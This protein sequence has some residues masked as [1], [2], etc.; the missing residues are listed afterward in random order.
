MPATFRSQGV[1]SNLKQERGYALLLVLLILVMISAIGLGMMY[2]SST[3]TAINGNYRDS[4]L[5]FSAMRG[6][7]EEARDRMRTNS[8]SPLNTAPNSV[9]AAMPGSL[10]SV[11]YITNAAGPTDTVDPLN[12]GNLYF[13]DEFCHE[14]FTGL[15]LSNPGAN[16]PCT[17]TM[18]ST[19]AQPYV[20]STSPYTNTAAALK[21][22]W[23]RITLKQN[24][25]M[26][27]ATVDA[28][29]PA[30]TQICYQTFSSQE[31]PLTL[32]P[33]GPYADCTAA[34]AAS[35]DAS[36]VY[37]LT[38]LAI[39]PQGSRR[40]GQ[41]EVAG[42]TTTPPPSA[43]GLD[44]PAAIFSPRP[45]SSLYF[46]NGTDSGAA[47]YT[48]SGGAGSCT[49]SGPANV[50]AISTGDSAGATAITTAITTNPDRSGN[51]T[52]SGG[53]P[54]VVNAGPG[55]TGQFSG[56]WSTPAQLDSLVNSLANAADVSYTCGIGAPC[57]PTGP[58]GTNANPQITYVNGDFNFGS[59]S[60]AGVLVVTGTLSFT[61]NASFN[62]LILV[63]GQGVVS[64]SG[65]GSGGFNGTMFLAK[66]HSSTSP[67]PELATLQSPLFSWNGGGSSFLQ[68]NSCWANIGN[69][70]AYGV[71]A[72][73]EEM[74]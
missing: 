22:K 26:P 1:P 48:S 11:L 52:G 9:P 37:V 28:G 46:I 58:V 27:N 57:T 67:Y 29:Q 41:Y 61:G 54:S 71:V 45:S 68:Y 10:G 38:S 18:P 69:K 8:G 15:S 63:I 55:G 5:A 43:L 16:V 17:S 50:P 21:Y 59:G 64:E 65:G 56:P 40:M 32:V 47:G 4:Q 12:S 6:G 25:S 33:G 53:T 72:M 2:T 7:L 34:Q 3:E 13:D 35:Q 36:P 60:G 44:G 14:S 62:G 70:M 74:Y 66:T 42:L 24:G 39:T 19:N 51:Y 30:G 23:T 73:R 31:I 49:P 20:A